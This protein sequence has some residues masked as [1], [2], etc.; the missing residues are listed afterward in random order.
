MKD[1]KTA[2]SHFT[3]VDHIWCELLDNNVVT[4]ETHFCV[5]MF[6]HK[7]K[8]VCSWP[9]DTDQT[10]KNSWNVVKSTA[11]APLEFELKTAVSIS[12][13]KANLTFL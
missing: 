10:E 12:L 3:F 8:S 11:A 5:K 4:Y 9:A 2:C 6:T 1:A 7:E 13:R